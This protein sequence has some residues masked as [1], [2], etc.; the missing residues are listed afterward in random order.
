MHDTPIF[1]VKAIFLTEA[2]T[3]AVRSWGIF[4]G[5][6]SRI[7]RRSVFAQRLLSCFECTSVW[8]CTAVLLYLR[9]FDIAAFDVMIV[10]ARAATIIHT[11]IEYLDALRA[12]TITRI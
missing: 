1:W 5:V 9:F 8:I 10:T 11:A 12:S 4:D 3:H 6:R 2:L 7:T